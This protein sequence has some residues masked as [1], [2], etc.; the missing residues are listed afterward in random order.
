[1]IDFAYVHEF[2]GEFASYCA[3]LLIAILLGGIL[4]LERQL[5]RQFA[6]IRTH[7]MV[8]LGACIFTIAAVKIAVEDP[9]QV[10]RV[11][12][13]IAAGIGFLGA[14]TILKLGPEVKVKGLT[15]AGSIWLAAALGTVAGMGEYALAAAAALLSMVVLWMLRPLTQSIGTR[16]RSQKG[17]K[18]DKGSTG[19]N[20]IEKL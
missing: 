13:G 7:M 18:R 11:I 17:A 16:R 2:I 14:G 15:T 9:S 1:M 12:Q 20:T 8:S 10:T 4:G 6:G 5:R 19:S 3:R